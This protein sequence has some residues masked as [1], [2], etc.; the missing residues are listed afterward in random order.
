MSSVGHVLIP[1][2]NKKP[3]MRSAWRDISA[4]PR[5]S[6]WGYSQTTSWTLPKMPWGA[7]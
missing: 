6:G 1:E 3:G 2:N 5:N 7:D 4:T